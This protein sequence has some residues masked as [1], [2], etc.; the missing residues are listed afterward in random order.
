M[1][2]PVIGPCGGAGQPACPPTPAAPTNETILY[3]EEV[4]AEAWFQISKER[5]KELAKEFEQ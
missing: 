1:P 4:I 3:P 2:V 5:R